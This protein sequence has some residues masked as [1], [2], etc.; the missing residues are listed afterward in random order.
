MLHRPALGRY[1]G[2]H[3][4][5]VLK[6]TS[7]GVT[8]LHERKFKDR[9]LGSKKCKVDA[10]GKFWQDA[11]DL[12]K[13]IEEDKK[14]RE[15][16]KK[17]RKQPDIKKAVQTDR[18]KLL[19]SETDSGFESGAISQINANQEN[20]SPESA[21]NA[22]NVAKKERI[23]A[24]TIN[25]RE[26]RQ[27]IL[28]YINTMKG[29]KELYFWTV[30]FPEGTP[31]AVCYQAFN[32]WLTA[33]RMRR[34]GK[35]GKLMR[36]MLREYLWIAERQLGD[37]LKVKKA[38]T[39]TIHFHIAIP[40]FMNV[41]RANALMRGT[42]KNL[43]KKGLMPG[44]ICNGKTGEQYYL[45]C[46]SKY[47]GVD[48]CKNRKTNR[49]VNFAAKKGSRALATYLTKYVTKND[50][51]VADST[52]HI[53]V[54]AF[55]HLAWHNSRGFSCLF[56]GVTFTIQEFNALGFRPFLNGVR[57][58]S[59]NFATFIPWLYGPPPLLHD[60]LFHLNSSVQAILNDEPLPVFNTK[61]FLSGP[62]P[63]REYGTGK[64]YYADANNFANIYN[65]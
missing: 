40:H 53:E 36:A 58:F 21:E 27:R 51:G 34:K 65:F 31:D 4:E 29:Q 52:G 26:V 7:T 44:A 1:P 35:D 48:I 20:F 60:H 19:L 39:G 3:T 49:I 55:T 17:S 46:I 11:R 45:P 6:A 63:R 47:N 2:I 14:S 10:T 5:L 9:Y 25:K 33:L 12:E 16:V 56:T 43:A 23:K 54:P 30:T 8:F 42:L 57:Q 64:L 24:Y 28:G 59:M 38:A 22:R 18:L 50:A 37:R 13:H 15:P 41:T 61:L 32:T 62:E